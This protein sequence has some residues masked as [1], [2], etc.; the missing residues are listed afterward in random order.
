MDNS[1]FSYLQPTKM[2][3]LNAYNKYYSLH[4]SNAFCPPWVPITAY[5]TFSRK[6]LPLPPTTS[7]KMATRQVGEVRH[8]TKQKMQTL[9]AHWHRGVD[10]P[11]FGIWNP[12]E[13]TAN[14]PLRSSLEV[15]YLVNAAKHINDGTTGIT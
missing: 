2:E 10:L 5:L 4:K 13:E 6:P 11:P 7:H 3:I 8:R 12:V 9:M 14:S 1:F 15:E